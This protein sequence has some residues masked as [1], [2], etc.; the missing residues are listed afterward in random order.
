VLPGFCPLGAIGLTA[1]S[2]AFYNGERIEATWLLY[3]LSLVY[4]NEEG[5]FRSARILRAVVGASRP[6]LCGS[7]TLPRQLARTPALR[8]QSVSLARRASTVR[9]TA[10]KDTLPGTVRMMSKKKDVAR[11]SRP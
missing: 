5:A 11:A 8:Y 4:V 7:E 3:L 1:F 6:H 2:E 9:L 10:G